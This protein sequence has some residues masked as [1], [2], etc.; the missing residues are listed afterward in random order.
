MDV[1]FKNN[2]GDILSGTIDQVENPI[3]QAVFSHCF[4][5]SNM[6]GSCKT[7]HSSTAL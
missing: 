3:A 2:R 7:K 5:L 4:K 6:Q 1:S